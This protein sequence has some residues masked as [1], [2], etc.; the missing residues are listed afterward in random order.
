MYYQLRAWDA[1]GTEWVGCE[2]VRP[3]LWTDMADALNSRSA[4]LR[5]HLQSIVTNDIEHYVK[6]MSDGECYRMI[7]PDA[8]RLMWTQ[9][10]RTIT[11]GGPEG[12]VWTTR[13]CYRHA[14]VGDVHVLLEEGNDRDG[15][16]K[17]AISSREGE[18][19]AFADVVVLQALQF[20]TARPLHASVQLR[21]GAH[22]HALVLVGPISKATRSAVPPPVGVASHEDIN[23]YWSIFDTFVGY[24]VRSELNPFYHRLI[25]HYLM[26]MDASIRHPAS[27]PLVLTVALEAILP[28]CRDTDQSSERESPKAESL[29][30]LKGVPVE[31]GGR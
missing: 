18:L 19:P 16:L 28:Y 29:D 5:G 14:Q 2:W 31:M 23:V 7:I 21:D 22:Q 20:L 12:R 4:E 25:E 9:G 8:G 15:T 11:S 13:S 27:Y 1:Q 17:V 30:E 10:R 26:V 24:L 6:P 3:D